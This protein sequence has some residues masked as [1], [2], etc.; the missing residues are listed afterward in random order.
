MCIRDSYSSSANFV[1][2]Y[3]RTNPKEDFACS[4]SAYFMDQLGKPFGGG[5]A[6]LAPGKMDFMDEF[7]DSKT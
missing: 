7:V 6:L 1:R 3:A 2:N 4:F 5:G